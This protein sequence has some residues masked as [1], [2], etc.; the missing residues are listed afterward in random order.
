MKIRVEHGDFGENE[1]VLRCSTLD[2]EMLEVLVL[3]RERT[4]KLAAHNDGETFMLSPGDIFYAESVDGR[5][6]IYTSEQVLNTRHS[7]IAL[8]DAYQDVGLLRISKS[9]VVNL[10]HVAKLKS[11]VN[12]RI[13][14]TLKNGEHLIVSR[15]YTQ[16]LKERLGLLEKEDTDANER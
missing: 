4:T 14:I 12:S 7:L 3:L 16:N 13:K 11:L 10:H 5:T 6:F 9:Q 15:H 8:Q 2:D 1:L